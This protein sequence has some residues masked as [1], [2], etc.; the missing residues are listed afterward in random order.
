MNFLDLFL[1]LLIVGFLYY[2]ILSLKQ[3]RLPPNTIVAFTGGLGS[4]KSLL[5]VRHA[6]Q[7]YRKTI[8]SYYF[9]RY[10]PILNLLPKKFKEKPKFYSNIPVRIGWFWYG[11][12]MANV[13]TYEHLTLQSR[14]E[15]HSTILIDELGQFANQYEY[16]NPFVQ[17]YIQE[18]IRFFRHY[19]DGR[20]FITDQ[21][22]SNIV[23]SVR[24][25]INQIYNLSNFTRILFFYKV[26][27]SEIH[28][29][30]DLLNIQDSLTPDSEQPYFF[31][32]MLPSLIRSLFRVK[33]RYD[34]R[35]YSINYHAPYS[36]LLSKWVSFKTDY[37]IEL[38]NNT[39]M[40]KLFKQQGYITPKQMELYVNEWKTAKQSL[41]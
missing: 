21:S 27:V 6:I 37:F 22:S 30:E 36:S 38:P 7:H 24:R 12:T 10:F 18:F 41:K 23:V 31:G 26:N 4:G 39:D 40:R 11:K 5:A 32:V 17:Q 19:V 9:E 2:L 34:S 8:R 29:T 20:M 15:E 25:R 35:C 3:K 14:I 16:D 28:I 13:L 33:P 1:I